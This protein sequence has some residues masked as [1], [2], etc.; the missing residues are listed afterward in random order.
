VRF[1]PGDELASKQNC[2]LIG[3]APFA[4]CGF[5]S[6]GT[7]KSGRATLQCKGALAK[8]GTAFFATAKQTLEPMPLKIQISPAAQRPRIFHRTPA[9]TEKPD[10]HDL[11][12]RHMRRWL[13]KPQAAEGGRVPPYLPRR[14]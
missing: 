2:R 11:F 4:A 6:P 14:S 7:L 13:A 8:T 12:P 5:A 1:I 3:F 9:N 10:E